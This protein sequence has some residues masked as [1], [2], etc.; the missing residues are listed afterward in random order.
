M[1][2]DAPILITGAAGRVGGVGREVVEILRER[3]LP[4]R[5]LVR[6]ED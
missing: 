1:S 4:V 3:D 6:T 5:A 2:I